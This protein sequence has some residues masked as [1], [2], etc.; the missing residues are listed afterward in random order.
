MREK[1]ILSSNTK[2]TFPLEPNTEMNLDRLIKNMMPATFGLS[3][4]HV[5]DKS[6]R[7][8]TKLDPARFSSTFNPYELGIVDA[9]AQTLLPSLRHSKQTRSVKAELYKLNASF[10]PSSNIVILPLGLGGVHATEQGPDLR[11]VR[12]L[13][14]P[15]RPPLIRHFEF[16]IADLLPCF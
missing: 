2:V 8:A 6:Y 7:K 1:T 4:E 13:P 16:V 3:G 5:Y 14:H 11:L 10:A 9:V 15:L 12:G